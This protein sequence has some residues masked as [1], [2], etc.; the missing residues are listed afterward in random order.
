MNSRCRTGAAPAPRAP[1]GPG[2][3]A[4]YRGPISKAVTVY[5]NDPNN[6]RASLR[7]KGRILVPIEVRPSEHI[8]MDGTLG[9]G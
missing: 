6:A 1:A 9:R 7:L 5:S 3:A 4:R 2:S 8:S